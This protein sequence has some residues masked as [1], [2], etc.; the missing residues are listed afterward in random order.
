MS[1][2]FSSAQKLNLPKSFIG[3]SGG[4]QPPSALLTVT[5]IQGLSLGLAEP[6]PGNLLHRGVPLA[7]FFGTRRS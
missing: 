6:D 4:S 3:G 7:C 5:D 1:M 2:H